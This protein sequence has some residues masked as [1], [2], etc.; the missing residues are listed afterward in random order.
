[1]AWI[2]S[3][4][5]FLYVNKAGLK[6]LNY[7]REEM[8]SKRV[9]DIDVNFSHKKWNEEYQKLKNSGLSG[10]KLNS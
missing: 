9:F 2:A 1:M 4:G 3:D 6:A 7:S 8:L 5:R 10:Y